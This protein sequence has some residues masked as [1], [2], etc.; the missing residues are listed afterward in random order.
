VFPQR[1]QAEGRP[2]TASAIAPRL[3]SARCATVTDV[4]PPTLTLGLLTAA[5]VAEDLGRQLADDLPAVL[6]DRVWGEVTWEVP[7]VTDE[8]AARGDSGTALIDAAR[9]RMLREGWDLAVVLSDLPL[10]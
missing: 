7:V 4:V 8:L 6:A 2:N 5:G 1:R 9:E 10:R 3:C